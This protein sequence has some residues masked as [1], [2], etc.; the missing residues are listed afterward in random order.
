MAGGGGFEA[1]PT[2][3]E[4][5]PNVFIGGKYEGVTTIE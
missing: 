3:Y 4:G 2:V 1:K 5:W